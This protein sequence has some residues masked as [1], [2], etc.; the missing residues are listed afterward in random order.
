VNLERSVVTNGILCLEG[1]D[2]L[3]PDH[4]VEDVL[5]IVVLYNGCNTVIVVVVMANVVCKNLGITMSD[6]PA[7]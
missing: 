6:I 1:G 2:A 5:T 4:F 7:P 3:F